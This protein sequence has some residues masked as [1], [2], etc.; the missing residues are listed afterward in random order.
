MPEI[1]NLLGIS[2]DHVANISKQYTSTG[3]MPQENQSGDWKNS[4]TYIKTD[5]LRNSLTNL[6]VSNRTIAGHKIIFVN[7]FHLNRILERS[8]ISEKN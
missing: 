4:S 2:K 7:N 5:L 8:Y 3:E 1:L 6:P